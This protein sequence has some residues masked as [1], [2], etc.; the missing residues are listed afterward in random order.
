[1]SRI[2]VF[3]TDN[4][5][6]GEFTAICNRGW[7]LDGSKSVSGGGQT[8]VSVSAETGQKDWLQF[9]RM[10]LVGHDKLPPWVGI[11]DTPWKASAPV[12]I[13]LYNAAYLLSLRTPDAPVVMTGTVYE[14]A[15]QVI[16]AINAQEEMYL[17]PG[18]MSGTDISRE[19]TFDQQSY[20]QRLNEMVARAGKE[21]FLRPAITDGRLVIY[22]DI[23]D[24]AGIDTGF[25]LHDG[26][27]ANMQI[28][29]ATIDGKIVNRLIGIGD[30]ST[31][32][33]RITTDALVDDPSRNAYRLRSSVI[34]YS[35]VSDPTTLLQ[36]ANINLAYSAWPRLILTLNILDVGDAFSYLQPGNSFFIQASKN[37]HLPGGVSGWRGIARLTALAYDEANNTVGASLE[38]QYGY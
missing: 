17:R 9:G 20:W 34:Q 29:D 27:N 18:V 7:M 6:R 22:L 1:M 12:Q 33:S 37:I 31:Q 23:Q 38:A 32:G 28:V 3:G 10:V 35:G 15:R 13:T 14:I 24:R 36:N 2:V 11:I 5:S 16:D 26:E 8:T 4:V 25:L 30:Q 19:Q 21:M